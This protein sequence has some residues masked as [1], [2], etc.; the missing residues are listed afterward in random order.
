MTI[1]L[2]MIE[3]VKSIVMKKELNTEV[4]DSFVPLI[5][6]ICQGPNGTYYVVDERNSRVLQ[7]SKNDKL[8]NVI[9]K[10]GEEAGEFIIPR[11]IKYYENGNDSRLYVLDN[12]GTRLQMFKSNG[13]YLNKIELST[14]IFNIDNNGNIIA[15]MRNDTN[16]LFTK[17]SPAGKILQ[18]L[19]PI[20]KN[21]ELLFRY[22]TKLPAEVVYDKKNNLYWVFFSASPDI[23]I[24]NGKG[25]LVK[26]INLISESIYESLEMLKKRW[27]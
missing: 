24:Y 25:N 8:L 10:R 14:D 21:D 18:R 16:Y 9:G 7:F 27:R 13:E 4:N 1:N 2:D 20:N 26:E 3:S 22:E 6:D 11:C 5:G 23:R 19:I 17:L 12:N 15:L